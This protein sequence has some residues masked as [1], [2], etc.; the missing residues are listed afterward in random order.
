MHNFLLYVSESNILK[1]KGFDLIV[2]GEEQLVIAVLYHATVWLYQ[3]LKH[4]SACET[5]I[6]GYVVK[7]NDAGSQVRICLYWGYPIIADTNPCNS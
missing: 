6:D 5:C 7:G 3:T 2:E 1:R 4:R